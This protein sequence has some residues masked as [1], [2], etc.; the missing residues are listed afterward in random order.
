[1]DLKKSR[2]QGKYDSKHEVESMSSVQ[3][4]KH[5]PQQTTCEHTYTHTT[6]HIHTHSLLTLLRQYGPKA[7]LRFSSL[8]VLYNSSLIYP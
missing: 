5:R 4:K 1:M 2:K 3:G 7:F 8:P 6:H